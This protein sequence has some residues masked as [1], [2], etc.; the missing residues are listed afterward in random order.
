MK[1]I[2]TPMCSKIRDSFMYRHK[3]QK[4]CISKG[5]DSNHPLSSYFQ[6][7]VMTPRNN[8][9][10]PSQTEAS[11]LTV[12]KMKLVVIY[13]TNK[14]LSVSDIFMV[15]NHIFLSQYEDQVIVSNL[16]YLCNNLSLFTRTN[17]SRMFEETYDSYQRIPNDIP[18]RQ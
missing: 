17:I 5:N 2:K 13:F 11:L 6:M 14:E 12:H 15:M 1:V 18:H 10:F 4:S 8:F 3:S 16:Y 9:K 7:S